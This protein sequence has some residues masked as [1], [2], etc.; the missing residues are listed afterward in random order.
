MRAGSHPPAQV[1]SH[2]ST[3]T[4]TAAAGCS[5]RSPGCPS[6]TRPGRSV[7]SSTPTQRTSRTAGADTLI[8]LGAGTC[9]K[10]R[11]ILDAMQSTGTTRRRFVPLDVSD[12]T[13]WE[14][15]DRLSAE[16]YPGPAVSA[17][18]G[19]LPPPP[20]PAADRRQPPLRLPRR[21]HRQ[22]RP[23]RAAR[24]LHA[25][26]QGH[27]PRRSAPARHRPGEGPLDVWSTPTTTRPG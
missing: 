18:V 13:L 23:R 16:E 11:I 19:R 26:R 10:S 22:P 21:N 3:S 2:P 6:T 8:E 17:V 5:T 1:S 20:R 12:T 14:A 24:V 27:G 9:D 7:R 25:A 15:A 4:T